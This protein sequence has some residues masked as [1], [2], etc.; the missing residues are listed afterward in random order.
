[1]LGFG[2]IAALPIAD[3]VLTDAP[4]APSFT[5]VRVYSADPQITVTI[6]TAR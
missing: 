1:M 6:E 2:P 3:D 4:S 5:T